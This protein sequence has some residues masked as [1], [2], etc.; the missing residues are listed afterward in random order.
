MNE[1]IVRRMKCAALIGLMAAG[2][3]PLAGQGGAPQAAAQAGMLSVSAEASPHGG[4]LF[5]GPQVIEI[6]VDDPDRSA[7]GSGAPVATVRAGGTELG[8]KQ[9][10]SGKWYAYV[11]VGGAV[12]SAGTALT[13]TAGIYL[14]GAAAGQAAD[15]TPKGDFLA[16]APDSASGR[17]YAADAGRGDVAVNNIHVVDASGKFDISYGSERVTL[18]YKENITPAMSANRNRSPPSTHVHIEITDFRLNLDPAGDDVWVFKIVGEEKH[19]QMNGETDI[20]TDWDLGDHDGGFTIEYPAP[21]YLRMQMKDDPPTFVNSDLGAI[22]DAMNAARAGLIGDGRSAAGLNAAIGGIAGGGQALAA[23][24]AAAAAEA[25]APS[26]TVQ[27]V[28]DAAKMALVKSD[29]ITFEETGANTGVFVSAEKTNKSPFELGPRIGYS[30]VLDYDDVE[31]QVILDESDSTLEIAGGGAWNSGDKI[32]VRVTNNKLNLNSIEDEDVTIADTHIPIL[33]LGKPVTL[34]TA[35]GVVVKSSGAVY[36]WFVEEHTHVGRL[37]VSDAG[38]GD[39]VEITITPTEGQKAA[40][41]GGASLIQYVGPAT[42]ASFAVGPATVYLEGALGPAT[43]DDPSMADIPVAGPIDAITLHYADTDGID[44]SNPLAAAFAAP[45]AIVLDVFTFN[46]TSGAHDAIYR[47]LLEAAGSP[48]VFEASMKSTVLN[49]LDDEIRIA[50]DASYIGNELE[51]V[52]SGKYA[53]SRGLV[54]EYEGN[55]AKVDAATNDGSVAFDSDGY[56]AGSKA[57]ITLADPDLQRDRDRIDTY[58]INATKNDG[59]E[60]LLNIAVAGCGAVD[61]TDPLFLRETAAGSGSFEASFDVPTRCPPDTGATTAGSSITATYYDFL[62]GGGTDNEYSDAAAII[63]DTGSVELDADVYPVP[64]EAGGEVVAVRVAVGD[65]DY[66][67]SPTGIDRID[68]AAVTITVEGGAV[69][70]LGTGENPL[71]ESAVDSGVFEGM[72]GLTNDDP[73]VPNPDGRAETSALP[74]VYYAGVKQGGVITAYYADRTDSSGS[75]NVAA[76]SATFDLR[77]AA[78]QTDRIEYAIGQDILITLVEPD[79]NYDSGVID[80]V[81]LARIQWGSEAYGGGIGHDAFGAVPGQLRETGKNTGTFQTSIAM[82]ERIDGRALEHGEGITLTYE[83][84]GTSGAKSAG[85]GYDVEAFISA[86][87]LV[88]AL[89]LDRGAYTWTD[90]AFVTVV[91]SDYNLNPDRIDEIGGRDSGQVN[92]ST[93]EGTIKDYRLVETGPDTGVFGGTIALSGFDYGSVGHDARKTG[94]SGPAGGFIESGN[95]DVLSVSFDRSPDEPPLVDS[96]EVRWSVGAVQWLEQAYAPADSGTVRVTDP[97]MNLDPDAADSI[98]ISVYSDTFPGGIGLTVIETGDSTGVFEGTV[99]FNP[100]LAPQGHRLHVAE[101]DIVTAVYGDATLPRPGGRGDS[102][103][104]AATALIGDIVPPLERAPISNPRM[105]DSF[106][107]GIDTASAG[108]QIQIAA[109]VTSGYDRDQDLTYIVQIRD[110]DGAV[111]GLS[112]L[113]GSLGAGG[114]M[115]PSQSWTPGEAGSYT[116]SLFVWE[117]LDNPIALSPQALLRIQVG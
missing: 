89:N 78:L 115:S 80:A 23:V 117:S 40:L 73:A 88:E 94:G 34:E 87:Y 74:D 56:Y 9:A 24:K 82:P 47:F 104:V 84:G 17:G 22:Y 114:T 30:Y 35:E 61:G 81:P 51:A 12:Y 95:V 109:D 112:W 98:E 85:D 97:D 91:A 6:V 32:A 96:A 8:M 11:V 59:R 102:L 77:T 83:D 50:R 60:T 105:V 36:E 75:G 92:I 79:L 3:I 18:E 53:G 86:S 108:Q 33:V 1:E 68:D 64:G 67:M 20:D 2:G 28:F 14:K 69:A 46:K 90:R 31:V 72:V 45:Q 42:S 54:V 63:S 107:N 55:H 100:N 99:N 57:T 7:T 103:D 106:G 4:N 16:G 101:G 62:D 43:T 71:I 15:L 76:D 111:V 70:T 52:L 66:N 49:Q 44:T 93:R 5:G 48:G 26:P 13:A 10:G 29:T 25:G 39:W 116:A 38:N 19:R 113:G 41:S 58:G 37:A 65:A 110:W 27:S 21:G